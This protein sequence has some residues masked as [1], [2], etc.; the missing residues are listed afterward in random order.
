MKFL[1]PFIV[2]MF[3][4][5]LNAED[6]FFRAIFP[7]SLLQKY[8]D[9]PHL[10]F[11]VDLHQVVLEPV[12]PEQR[13]ALFAKY[14]VDDGLRPEPVR[15]VAP[16]YPY[17]QMQEGVSGNATVYLVISQDGLVTDVFVGEYTHV[18]FAKAAAFGGKFWRFKPSHRAQLIGLPIPFSSRGGV[19]KKH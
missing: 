6:T 17:E 5:V 18:N 15:R 1:F 14:S 2:L 16:T 9:D 3:P 13:K 10:F 7:P 19:R 8:G 12:S 4:C 11:E